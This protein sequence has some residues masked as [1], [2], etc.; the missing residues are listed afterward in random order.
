[1]NGQVNMLGLPVNMTIQQIYYVM[2]MGRK[3]NDAKVSL[4]LGEG[5]RWLCIHKRQFNSFE[6]A[7]NYLREDQRNIL[8]PELRPAYFKGLGML[9]EMR[10]AEAALGIIETDLAVA[11]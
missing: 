3:F 8:A 1:M 2:Y 11:A 9:D 4:H 7:L 10:K 5:E 6:N